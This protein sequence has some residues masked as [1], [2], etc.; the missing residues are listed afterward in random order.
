MRWNT[1]DGIASAR[2]ATT[3][4]SPEVIG[5]DP[6]RQGAGDAERLLQQRGEFLAPAGDRGLFQIAHDVGARRERR[7]LLRRDDIEIHQDQA[8]RLRIGVKKRLPQF[9]EVR[10]LRRD[11][12]RHGGCR[13]GMRRCGRRGFGL[14]NVGLQGV[15]FEN[16]EF[17]VA[18]A[19]G[20]RRM[21][22]ARW[23]KGADSRAPQSVRDAAPPRPARSDRSQASLRPRRRC[24]RPPHRSAEARARHSGALP[25]RRGTASECKDR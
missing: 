11:E 7:R 16:I 23:P 2:P 18:P 15:G 8:A 14:E 3:K 19:R 20:P 1:S 13:R 21:R 9:D 25:P 4:G 24:R 22:C 10:R 5:N 6:G 17:I 12:G